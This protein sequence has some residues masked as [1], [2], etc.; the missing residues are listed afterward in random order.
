MGRP[1]QTSKA[2]NILDVN[3]NCDI[4]ATSAYLEKEGKYV[5]KIQ[6]RIKKAIIPAE[7]VIYGG[8]FVATASLMYRAELEKKD[9][10]FRKFL[11][12][13]YA[14]QIAGSLS[15][16]MLF[17]PDKTIVYRL[18]IELSWSKMIKK[19]KS[20]VARRTR[21]QSDSYAKTVK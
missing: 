11:R 5:G 4:C 16:G 8:G 12:F 3:L 1:I 6:P 18:E 17:L 15:G 9:F 19:R 10:G 2:S 7:E 14:L 20:E 21:K 13:A